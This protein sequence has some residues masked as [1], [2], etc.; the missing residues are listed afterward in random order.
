MTYR[1]HRGGLPL[2]LLVIAFLVV[3]GT[4]KLAEAQ[5][6]RLRSVFAGEYASYLEPTVL[7]PHK[8]S[9]EN[10]AV[11][12]SGER[13]LTA[14]E[15][16]EVFLW[17]PQTKDV[18]ALEDVGGSSFG[19]LFLPDKERFLVAHGSSVKGA[20]TCFELGNPTKRLFSIDTP[21][22]MNQ[23]SY[24]ATKAQIV[25]A[26]YGWLCRWDLDDQSLLAKYEIE[27]APL[28]ISR[29]GSLVVSTDRDRR[30]LVIRS[31]DTGKEVA[32]VDG[33]EKV[34]VSAASISHDDVF[35][36]FGSERGDISTWQ[37]GSSVP[38]RKLYDWGVPIQS[39]DY[40]PEKPWLVG[41]SRNWMIKMSNAY[42]RKEIAGFKAHYRPL[43][44]VAFSSDGRFL[45]TASADKSA[46]IWDLV[47]E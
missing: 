43:T 24:S 39:L 19:L 28:A 33:T 37:I 26:G 7:R 1:S 46:R 14:A 23:L 42:T 30:E 29:R 44:T 3:S 31:T 47:K 9:V 21:A 5:F 27:Y 22:A 35:V 34:R 10:V 38:P 17:N 16:G 2:G 12:S 41:G 40:A 15:N 4:T 8:A 11:S 6:G 32:R 36:A 18:E 20:I 25:G 45:V 13:V